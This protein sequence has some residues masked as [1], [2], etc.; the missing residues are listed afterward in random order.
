MPLALPG[1]GKAPEGRRVA[2]PGNLHGPRV[3]EP[4]PRWEGGIVP[5]P[6]SHS[7]HSPPAAFQGLAGITLMLGGARSGKSRYAESLL[8][9]WPGRRTYLA[10][11]S[12]GDAEM[13]ERIRRHRERRGPEWTTVEAPLEIADAIRAEP[14]PIL[15]DCLTLWVSNLMA[16][17]EAPDEAVERLAVAARRPGGP[18]LFVSNEVGLGIVPDNALAREFRDHAGRVNQ[19]IAAIADRVVFI[20]AGLPLMLKGNLPQ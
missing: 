14:G 6:Q 8:D 11:G 16:A 15:V 20:A 5:V 18:V 12:A 17:G 9:R 10:T 4:D 19:R 1:A 7:A 3:A 13:A 2:E